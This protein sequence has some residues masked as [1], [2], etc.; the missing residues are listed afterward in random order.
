MDSR[1]PCL[2]FR[3]SW[4]YG[5]RG[6]NF[7]LTMLRLLQ[8]R[9]ELSVVD[10]QIGTP[11]WAREIAATTVKVIET[12][13]GGM[14]GHVKECR[15]VYHLTGHGQTTWYHFAEAIAEYLQGRGKPVAELKAI[16]TSEYP[17]PAIRPAYSV[18]D[19]A[20]LKNTFGVE[21]SHWREAVVQCLAEMDT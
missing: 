13:D 6:K 9:Q 1:A 4:V 10:D 12:L 2:I 17:T 14:V 5:L 18:L 20:K 7:L 16:P 21:L 15:G 11:T 8:E 3:T 19:N